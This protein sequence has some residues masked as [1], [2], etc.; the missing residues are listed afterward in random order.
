M[1]VLT[2]LASPGEGSPCRAALAQY[3][4]HTAAH[5]NNTQQLKR[6]NG[7]CSCQLIL[8]PSRE[9]RKSKYIYRCVRDDVPSTRSRLWTA[10][11]REREERKN[12]LPSSRRDWCCCPF[13]WRWHDLT[14][15]T[16]AAA[17]MQKEFMHDG[18]CSR[19]FSLMAWTKHCLSVV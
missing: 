17:A 19:R 13:C 9:T 8:S 18:G 7:T 14:W 12:W 11:E 6:A 2:H 1:Y 5:C 16:V 4:R 10:K 3:R 15:S